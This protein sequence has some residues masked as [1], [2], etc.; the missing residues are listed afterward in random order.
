MYFVKNQIL[1]NHTLPLWNNMYLSG[2]PL[3]ADPQAPLFYLPNLLILVLPID[4]GIILSIL[5]HTVA[6]SGFFYLLAH[7]AFKLDHKASIFA[8]LIYIL[9]PRL[10]AYLEA[11][12]LGL[13]F[14]HTWI[15]LAIFSAIKLALSKKIK[16]GIY[17]AIA[18]ALLFFTHT[19]TFL[20]VAVCTGLVMLALR[21]PILKIMTSYLILFGLVAIALLPQIVWS[22]LSTRQLLLNHPETYPVWSSKLEFIIALIVPWNV[23]NLD[24]EKAI[25]FGIMPLLISVFAFLKLNKKLKLLLFALAVTIL[26]I[27]LNN[28]SPIYNILLTQNWF[29]LMRVATRV[30]IIPT[31]IVCILSGIAI[32]IIKPKLLV[33]LVMVITIGELFFLSWK[34]QAKQPP[35]ITNK[36]PQKIIDLI[37]SDPEHFR[38]FCTSGCISQKTAT[39][40][41]IELIEGYNTLQQINYYKYAWQYTGE[42]WDYYTLAIPPFGIRN[43]KLQNLDTNALGLLNTKYIISP[44]EIDN[45]SL[46][47]VLNSEGYMVYLNEDFLPRAFTW[48]DKQEVKITEYLPNSITLDASKIPQDTQI[49]LS[50]VYSPGWTANGKFMNEGPEILRSFKLNNR[51]YDVK[52]VYKPYFNLNSFLSILHIKTAQNQ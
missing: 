28:A 19:I 21:G 18:L 6:A 27:S 47:F 49:V 50:E 9:I 37:K 2:Y 24:T 5:L 31:V 34:V 51:S 32:P 22:G 30:W 20:I 36:A 38:V 44:Y 43:Q 42:W 16:F 15:P 48:P 33:Y 8:S 52:I 46:E 23:A 45:D 29:V 12:H 1:Q 11:G 7:K 4:T 17:C 41:N 14:A 25:T 39:T 13:I 10:S 3:V 40:N 26:I 35:N